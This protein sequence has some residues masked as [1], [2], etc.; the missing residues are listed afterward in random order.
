[1]RLHAAFQELLHEERSFSMAPTAI[2]FFRE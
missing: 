1:M 2:T